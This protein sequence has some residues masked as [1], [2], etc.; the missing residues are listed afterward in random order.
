MKVLHITTHD[1]GGA[2]A[3]AHRLHLALRKSGLQSE[4]LVLYNT[5]KFTDALT[6]NP[7][8]SSFLLKKIARR[9]GVDQSERK[10]RQSLASNNRIELFTS[11][12]TIYNVFDFERLY[13]FDV[14]HLHW[15]ADFID[16]KTFFSKI[17]LPVVWTFHDESPLLGGFHYSSDTT[18]AD[19][20]LL[21]IDSQYRKKKI[22]SISAM[23]SKL[24]VIAPSRWLLNEARDS[25]LGALGE[26]VQIPY[27]I[28]TDTYTEIDKTQVRSDL[29]I[30]T[31]KIVIS[32]VASDLRT[33][34]KGYDLF[35]DVCQDEDV[36]T[37]VHFVVVGDVQQTHPYENI[38]YI[39]KVNDANRLNQIYMASDALILPS[40]QDNLPNVMVEALVMG[41]PVLAFATGGI[42]DVIETNVN[43]NLTIDISAQGL[44]SMILEFAKSPHKFD[45]K[46]IRMMA[47]EKFNEKSIAKQVT[48][49]YQRI[50]NTNPL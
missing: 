4:F 21:Q 13:D 2:A 42:T 50:T 31:N 19:E 1:F 12:D 28:D 5:N 30:K 38:T 36:R 47:V 9:F 20:K 45:R 22:D 37:L 11:P 17:I 46:Q 6:F 26:L 35:L 49:F 15:V 48:L 23:T 39:G 32:I 10:M 27:C 25:Y 18:F 29:A 14:I 33:F 7:K 8:K 44:K 43:G 40:R 34:R 16:F 3:A 41:C 24:G